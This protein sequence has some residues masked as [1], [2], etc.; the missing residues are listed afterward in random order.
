MR[1]DGFVELMALRSARLEAR[2]SVAERLRLT[3]DSAAWL[4]WE[5][6]RVID[7]IRHAVEARGGRVEMS[8]TFRD[9]VIPLEHFGDLD[10][11][12]DDIKVWCQTRIPARIDHLVACQPHGTVLS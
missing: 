1:T 2:E 12:D 8:V 5:A 11:E 3:S 9:V 10:K 4:E 7:A 6:D